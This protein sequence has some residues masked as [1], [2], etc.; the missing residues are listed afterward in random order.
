MSDIERTQ[1]QGERTATAV[2]EYHTERKRTKVRQHR[3]KLAVH[4]KDPEF[5][6]RWVLDA[7]DSGADI[8]MRMREDWVLVHADE[9]S[10]IGEDSIYK[11]EF[12]GGSIVRIL[13]NGDGKYYYLMKIRK[14]W[15]DADQQEKADEIDARED[16]VMGRNSG[17]GYDDE[18]TYDAIA[19]VQGKSKPSRI[20]GITQGGK[21]T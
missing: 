9:V 8:Q 13:A 19:G 15:Y 18:D 10:G 4:G 6:Y 7:K 11:S 17:D 16:A 2:P 21:P 3:S 1:G 5:E 14:E 20:T 12:A